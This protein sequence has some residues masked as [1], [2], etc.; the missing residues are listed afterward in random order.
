MSTFGCENCAFWDYRFPNRL[1]VCTFIP[2]DPEGTVAPVSADN[3]GIDFAI[4][5]QA[6][7]A[8]AA[9]TICNS[10]E[11]NELTGDEEE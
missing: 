8:T 1:G 5:Y 11:P 4:M 2:D 6:N 9:D 3:V 7:T 10:W